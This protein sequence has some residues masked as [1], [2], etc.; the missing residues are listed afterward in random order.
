VDLVDEQDV[1]GVHPGEDR[2]EVAGVGER[3]ATGDAQ[4][5]AHLGGD[6]HRQRGLAEA[7][8]A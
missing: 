4:R 2:G 3:R 7:R 1:A 5:H 6:D 8:R